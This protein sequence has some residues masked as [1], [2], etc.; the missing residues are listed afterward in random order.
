MTRRSLLAGALALACSAQSGCSA[1]ADS[2]AGD[3]AP[4]P[5]DLGTPAQP[6]PDGG[7][8]ASAPFAAPPVFGPNVLVFDPSMPMSA[9]QSR[10]DALYAQQDAAQFGAGR[11][12]YLFKPGHYALDVKVGFYTQVLG[13]GASPDDVVITGAV[14]SKADWLG[15]NNA[16]CNFWRGAE[17][18]AVVPSAAID[19]GIDVWAVSQGT[20]LRR[21]HVEGDLKLDDG[22]WSSGGFIADSIVDGTLTSG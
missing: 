15:N 5:G 22:G 8:P 12:A 16:T 13:L 9:I 14:R 11:Y 19:A 7:G 4:A 21:V 10:L 1:T 20:Q 2:N 3:A 17:N 18:L 6:A